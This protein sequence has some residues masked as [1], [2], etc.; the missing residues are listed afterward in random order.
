LDEIK[1][2]QVFARKFGYGTQFVDLFVKD[3][4]K[5]MREF[6]RQHGFRNPISVSLNKWGL[7]RR[8]KVEEERARKE[9][10][11]EARVQMQV[12][13]DHVVALCASE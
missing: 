6:A 12:L 13:D 5:K 11:E 2:K 7:E 10:R 4:I 1:A 9:A 8:G 3:H